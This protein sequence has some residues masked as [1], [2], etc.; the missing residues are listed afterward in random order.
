M[1]LVTNSVLETVGQT[2]KILN[3]LMMCS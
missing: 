1:T 2:M 3:C